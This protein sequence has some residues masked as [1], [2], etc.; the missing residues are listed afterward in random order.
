[1]KPEI[2]PVVVFAYTRVDLLQQLLACLR[3]DQVPLLYVFCD[4]PKSERQRPATEAVRQLVR[5]IDWCQVRS[6]ERSSNMGL[7]QSIL[8]GVTEVLSRHDSVI[9]FEDDLVFA[10]GTY[11][12]FCE[13]LVRYQAEPKVTSIT[14]WTHP[15]VNPAG[16]SSAPYFDGRSE[17]WSF[18]TWARAWSG[19]DV[20]AAQR[21][22][23]C[24]IRDIDVYRY[25]ADLVA[26]ARAE[27][28][29]NLWAVR[30][31]YHHMLQGGLCLR[32]GRSL[33]DHRGTDFE[34]TNALNTEQWENPQLPDSADLS[35]PWPAPREAP[36]C[37]QLWQQACGGAPAGMRRYLD[38]LKLLVSPFRDRYQALRS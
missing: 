38:D 37:P 33:V 17:S 29:R 26:M 28:L 6:T 4:G 31:A 25:G 34:A 11:R 14:G 9:V 19:M 12:F 36:D 18:A 15:S 7:G 1:M 10:P 22:L 23:Q 3:R 16:T 13:G 21:Y 32:P 2:V 20:G 8:T 35:G 30:W 27:H 24:R 5:S